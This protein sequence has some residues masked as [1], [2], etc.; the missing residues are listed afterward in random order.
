MSPFGAS[1]MRTMSRGSRVKL[2]RRVGN[3][4]LKNLVR[5]KIEPTVEMPPVPH[6]APQTLAVVNSGPETRRD[7]GHATALPEQTQPLFDERQIKVEVAG[8]RA[9]I[10][11]GATRRLQISDHIR[12]DL[13]EILQLHVRR[14]AEHDIEAAIPVTGPDLREGDAPLKTRARSS[15]S[16]VRCRPA[17]KSSA[18][19]LLPIRIV[20]SSEDSGAAARAVCSQSASLAI[21]TDAGLISTP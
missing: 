5:L 11:V 4:V 6:Q 18:T 20:C 8:L 19:R 16:G 7:E 3:H 12:I 9:R 17:Q 14:V 13:R 21:S 2:Q 1:A 15:T 10:G